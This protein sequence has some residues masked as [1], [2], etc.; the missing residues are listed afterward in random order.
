M[1]LKTRNKLSGTRSHA[2]IYKDSKYHSRTV[3]VQAAG[4]AETDY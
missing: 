3:H 2:E 4:D 1:I